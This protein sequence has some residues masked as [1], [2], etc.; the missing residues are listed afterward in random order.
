M[1]PRSFEDDTPGDL[2]WAELL[3]VQV[4]NALALVLLVLFWPALAVGRGLAGMV[5]AMHCEAMARRLT[6]PCLTAS[7]AS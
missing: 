6:R 5:R 7:R 2:H 3:A 4:L 1:T